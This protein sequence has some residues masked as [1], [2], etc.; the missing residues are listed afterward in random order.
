MENQGSTDQ[1][2]GNTRRDECNE[3]GG[4]E[5]GK[6]CERSASRHPAL[7]CR[8]PASVGL[9]QYLVFEDVIGNIDTYK[10]PRVKRNRG[11]CELGTCNPRSR[12]TAGRK[13]GKDGRS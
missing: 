1:T 9:A 8:N 5:A 4:Q 2:E 6:N 3:N 7:I 13:P 12:K 11:R 10:Q